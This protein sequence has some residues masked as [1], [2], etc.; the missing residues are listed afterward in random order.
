MKPYWLLVF[1][2]VFLVAG[3]WVGQQT[4]SNPS[5]FFGLPDSGSEPSVFFC[6]R[7]SCEGQLVERI[8]ASA[9]SIDLAIYSFTLDSVSQAL[10]EAH[11]RSVLVR[12]L[13][14]AGQAS[15][16]Y[17]VDERLEEA[18]VP[19]QRLDL[20]RGIMHNKYIVIDGK[21]VGTGSFNYSQN[22]SENNRE[23]LVFISNPTTVQ[24]YEKDFEFLWNSN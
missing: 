21:L 20:E 7:D 11:Q 9:E 22:A 14:D 10:I 16:Q 8:A 24:E 4:A 13:F 5:G 6:P 3:F 23:N 2:F 15:S 18:G 19:I 17:S 1:L 12:V